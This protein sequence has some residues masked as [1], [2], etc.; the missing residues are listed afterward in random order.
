MTG[1][2][3]S[4]IKEYGVTKKAWSVFRGRHK[5]RSTRVSHSRRRARRRSGFMARY[6]HSRRR[7]GGLGLGGGKAL[8]KNVAVGMGAGVLVGGLLGVG[9]GFLLGGPAGAAGAY[10]APQIANAVKGIAGGAQVTGGSATYG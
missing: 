5:H 6:R 1:L 4:I 3:A 8:L 7:R 10:F 2:P 9:A